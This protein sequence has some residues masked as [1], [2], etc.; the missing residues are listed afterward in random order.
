M[1]GAWAWANWIGGWVGCG[2]CRLQ[3]ESTH[4]VLECL[5]VVHKVA[6]GPGLG[7]WNPICWVPLNVL[8]LPRELVIIIPKG[9]AQRNPA[10]S[11]LVV[12][13]ERH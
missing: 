5:T 12:P 1:I 8:V 6:H 9:S 13:H 11:A 4:N 2:G 10:S 3:F 7:F